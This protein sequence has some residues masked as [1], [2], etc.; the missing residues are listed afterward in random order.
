MPALRRVSA[1]RVP[2]PPRPPGAAVPPWSSAG[3]LKCGL[4]SRS[5]SA[6]LTASMTSGSALAL[7]TI[8]TDSPDFSTPSPLPCSPE[9]LRTRARAAAIRSSTFS[10]GLKYDGQRGSG[11]SSARR[12]QRDPPPRAPWSPTCRRPP[13]GERGRRPPGTANPVEDA[14]WISCFR[15]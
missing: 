4:T 6:R 12:L 1:S 10:G 9:R 2:L 14:S 5:I 3:V 8:R 11:T 15:Q 13:Q 7:M